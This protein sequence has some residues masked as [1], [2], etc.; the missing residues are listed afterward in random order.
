MSVER[1]LASIEREFTARVKE[2][3]AEYRAAVNEAVANLKKVLF[4]QEPFFGDV[5]DPACGTGRICVAAAEAGLNA[6]GTDLRNRWGDSFPSVSRGLTPTLVQQEFTLPQWG[7]VNGRTA[8]WSRPTNIVSNP[9]FGLAMSFVSK[10]LDVAQCKVAM[11]LPAKWMYGD[12]RSRWLAQTPL[13]K[14]LAITPRPSMP[15]GAVIQAGVS[16]GGGKEDFAWFIWLQGYRGT[17]T[18]GWLWRDA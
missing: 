14:V 3:D 7:F 12:K 4:E 13:Y 1:L 17:P 16:P 8:W 11:L 15:P 10:A 2:A 9:P 5:V 6:V 18:T